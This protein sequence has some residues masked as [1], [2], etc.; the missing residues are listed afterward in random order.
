M[1]LSLSMAFFVISPLKSFSRVKRIS[2]MLMVCVLILAIFFS[3]FPLSPVHAQTPVKG[4]LI[5][6]DGQRVLQVYGTH[7]EM[8]YAHGYLLGNDIMLMIEKYLIEYLLS[9][10][11]SGWNTAT[12]RMQNKFQFG[13][14]NDEFQGVYDGMVAS[15]TDMR[16]DRLGRNLT[17]NDLKLWSSMFDVGL[18]SPLCS[19]FAVWDSASEG[20]SVLHARNMDFPYDTQNGYAAN[21]KLIIAYHPTGGQQYMV[22]TWPGFLS[23]GTGMNQSQL[24]LTVNVAN[25]TSDLSYNQSNYMPIGIHFREILEDVSG[26]GDLFPQVVAKMTSTKRTRSMNT[27]FSQPRGRGP[28]VSMFYEIDSSGQ[29]IR[30]PSGNNNYI[31]ATN[32]F[33]QRASADNPGSNTYT[34]YNTLTSRLNTYTTT[35]DRAVSMSEAQTIMRDLAISWPTLLTIYLKPEQLS[36]EIAFAQTT[37]SNP[38]SVTQAP[39]RPRVSYTWAELFAGMG[40]S[41]PTNTPTTTP[42]RTPTNSPTKTPTSTPTRTLTPSRTPTPS[43]TITPSRT[44]TKSPTPTTQ[45]STQP[46][47]SPTTCTGDLN[48]DSKVNLIDYSILVTHFNK[49]PLTNPNADLNG[50]GK[51]D[52]IDYSI[53]IY[54]YNK[55]CG[56]SF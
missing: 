6:K 27:H 42:T 55:P 52:L 22:V 28:Q 40:N 37:G 51:V 36:F 45:P 39:F 12:T 30:Y 44:P 35:G 17:V 9:N 19:S 15:N 32:H 1:H 43:H 13:R 5:Q 48:A 41:T 34:R 25:G 56:G 3:S 33:V 29:Q 49:T 31:F 47:V 7:Y 23:I 53:L 38:V 4:R 14:F 2:R 18:I 26:S 11:T 20:G 24:A 50:D 10:N 46:S 8:G 21:K 16:I 54:N